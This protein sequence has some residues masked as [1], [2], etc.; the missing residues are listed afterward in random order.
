MSDI[1]TNPRARLIMQ[2]R[3]RAVELRRKHGSSI[4]ALQLGKR[5]QGP[6]HAP[7]LQWPSG[8]RIASSQ[9]RRIEGPDAHGKPAI[10]WQWAAF[11]EAG[12][13]LQVCEFSDLWALREI[14]AYN[15]A[16]MYRF[17]RCHKGH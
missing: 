10:T 16:D 17:V 5:M 4:A 3:Q 11:D 8:E 14:A 7:G 2:A 13:V 12:H 15:V 1:K 9:F 6:R